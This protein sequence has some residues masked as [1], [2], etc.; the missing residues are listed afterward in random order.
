MIKFC[1]LGFWYAPGDVGLSLSAVLPRK[2]TPPICHFLL[3]SA[4]FF[5]LSLILAFSSWYRQWLLVTVTRAR[6]LSR[7][8]S[9]W[10]LSKYH[11][12]ANAWTTDLL[13]MALDADCSWLSQVKIPA[14]SNVSR[15]SLFIVGTF[16]LVLTWQKGQAIS[17]ISCWT[18]CKSPHTWCN[19][20]QLPRSC[21][22]R[23]LDFTMWMQTFRPQQLQ[24]SKRE[25]IQ[26]NGSRLQW[27]AAWGIVIK[28]VPILTL[29]ECLPP[30]LFLWIEP[31]R[32]I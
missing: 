9:V 10:A 26:S 1:S 11:T 27:T 20:K 22:L 7:W 24:L 25:H 13:L 18:W 6:S 12:L 17:L 31:S 30:F 3:L 23:L 32:D 5:L 19:S 16:N 21:F 28:L 8:Q 2:Q 15:G 14:D 29:S 4:F